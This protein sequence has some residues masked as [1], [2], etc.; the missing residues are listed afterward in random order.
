MDMTASVISGLVNYVGRVT[1]GM[2][3]DVEAVDLAVEDG[4]ATVILLMGSRVPTLTE[5]PLLLTW[6]EVSGWALRVETDGEGSTTALAHLEED[7][8]PNPRVVRRFLRDAIGGAHP[9]SPTAQ[10]FRLPDDGDGLESRIKRFIEDE[11]QG[12]RCH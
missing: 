7:V 3:D 6:D 11:D 1:D 8:L 2:E 5:L 12:W 9:G 4:L 10:A